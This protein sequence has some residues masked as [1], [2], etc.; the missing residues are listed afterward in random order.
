MVDGMRTTIRNW[1]PVI[2]QLVVAAAT[3]GAIAMIAVG[4]SGVLSGGLGAAFGKPFV[5]G[6]LPGTTYS[7]S[8][9]A[10]FHEYHPS[11]PTC[12][13]AAAAHHFDEVVTYRLAAGL[14]GLVVLG[15][16][17]LL[18]RRRRLA[19]DL[20][21]DGFVATM[22][23]V[24]FGLAALWCGG[25]AIDSFVLGGHTGG[26]GQYLS[27]AIASAIAF[28]PFA[29]SLLDTFASRLPPAMPAVA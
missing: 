17:A 11:A 2:E 15:A 19:W 16:L 12:A 10:D 8:R 1:K 29:R 28:V 24:G 20:L 18:R 21:P 3:L 23:C 5:S 25:T 7:A 4:A 9:C 14:L 22:G 27:G 26:A 6:D 13:A